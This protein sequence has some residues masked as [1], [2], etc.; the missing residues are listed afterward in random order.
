MLEDM[1]AAFALIGFGIMLGFAICMVGV[2]LLLCLFILSLPIVAVLGIRDGVRQ[3][4][5]AQMQESA[6]QKRQDVRALRTG[7][8]RVFMLSRR[9]RADAATRTG[10]PNEPPT[11]SKIGPA[12]PDQAPKFT[13]AQ[14][15]ALREAGLRVNTEN[16]EGEMEEQNAAKTPRDSSLRSR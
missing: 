7:K 12:V 16:V 4:Q 2:V 8:G 14:A 15:Q 10:L 6:R 11:F 5:M 9:R 3:A 1:D 13:P